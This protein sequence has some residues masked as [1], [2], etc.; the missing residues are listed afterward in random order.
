MIVQENHASPVVTVRAHVR[1]GGM[2]EGKWLGCGLSHLVEH[3]V[4]EGA[5]S[6]PGH[7]KAEKARRGRVEA[8][9]AQSNASTGIDQTNYYIDVSS[10]RVA[11]AISIVCD[12]MARPGFGEADFERE[13]GVVQRE[14]EMGKD[15]A[16]RQLEYAHMANFYGPHP[17]GVPVIGYLSALQSLTFQDVVEYHA[18]MY[19]PQNMVFI[20]VG[21]IDTQ[22]VLKQICTCM[23]GFTAERHPVPTLPEV[24]YLAGVRRVVT[25]APGVKD[26]DEEIGFRTVELLNPDMY[27]LDVLAY[28]LTN[29]ETSRLEEVLKRQ[30]KLVTSIECSSWTP[31]WGAGQFEFEFRCDPQNADEAERAAFD[32]TGGCGG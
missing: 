18:Q 28:V 32:R 17:A 10:S 21:D 31:E 12:W 13:H 2:L 3:L 11:E 23:A 8:I 9:G 16:E 22:R 26:V 20:V 15:Q 7:V 24:P 25:T 27:A 5:E 29:G 1:A 14:L 4:A 30:R 19:V 6:G